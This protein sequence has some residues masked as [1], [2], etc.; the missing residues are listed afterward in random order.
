[1]LWDLGTGKL[2]KKMLGHKS[3]I[4]S[5]DFSK[6]GSILVS[7]SADGTVRLWDVKKGISDQSNE[8]E[9]YLGKIRM[10]IDENRS[11]ATKPKPITETRLAKSFNI[12]YSFEFSNCA[13]ISSYT[14]R[15][16]IKTLPTKQTPVYKIQFTRRNLC[17]AAGAYVP[18]EEELKM[19]MGNDEQKNT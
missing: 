9:H 14:F 6:E 12:Q 18:T 4:Y 8:D 3:T 10:D 7:G 19:L 16:L 2:L 5:L 1:M 17:L 11:T 15:D 13:K